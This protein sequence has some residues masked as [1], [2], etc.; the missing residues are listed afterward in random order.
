MKVKSCLPQAPAEADKSR[1]PC[2]EQQLAGTTGT[3]RKDGVHE[4]QKD[5]EEEAARR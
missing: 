4:K 1:P 2:A 3:A 5:E